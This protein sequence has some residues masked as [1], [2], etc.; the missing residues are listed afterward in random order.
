MSLIEAS[1]FD[2]ESSKAHSVT[3]EILG[4]RL[5]LRGENLQLSLGKKALRMEP[6][7]GEAG[8]VLHLE[9]GGEIHGLSLEESKILECWI[10]G[11]SPEH[12][13]R[14]FEGKLRYVALSILLAL[15]VL[16]AGIF[17]GLPQLSL[18]VAKQ[19]PASVRLAMDS[20]TLE[21]LDR[22]YLKE[23]TLSLSRQEEIKRGLERFC[24][25]NECGAHQLLFRS[26]PVLGANAFALAGEVIILSDEL[27]DKSEHDEEIIAVLAHEIGHLKE[28]HALRMLLQTLGTGVLISVGVGD[29]GAFADLAAGIPALLLQRG[30]SREMEREADAFALEGLKRAGI[31]PRRLA[32]ILLRLDQGDETPSILLTHPPTKE[33][34]EP[35]LEARP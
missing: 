24:A 13:A 26:S 8:G 20:E 29:V 1:Y 3:L 11:T 23:S 4:D 28:S 25:V 27:V 19:A 12:L 6:S 21:I 31:A 15:G 2:G 35:F 7:V 22:L 17:Y 10:G 30:Y 18:W 16:W 5:E 9:S 33:R 34:I 32:E 14:F